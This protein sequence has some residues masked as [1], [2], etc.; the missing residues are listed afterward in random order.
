MSSGPITSWQIDG[1]TVRLYF[2]GLQNH[3][4]HEI[5]RHL[6]LGRKAMTNLDSILKSRH[7]FAN[8]D[9]YSQRCSFSSSQVWVWVLDL[10]EG[11][12]Q[13]NWCF[14]IDAAG[15]DSSE[16]LRLQ[17]DQIINLKRNQ[18]WIFI[19][20]TDAEAEAPI[21][22]PPDAKG[23]LIGKDPDAGKDW[24]Q[25]EKGM[26]EVEMVGWHHWLNGRE[27]EKTP[28]DSEGQGSLACCSPWDCKELDMTERLN[29]CNF[30]CLDYL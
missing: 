11:W 5:N 7:H 10:K 20:R 18:P 17:G 29:K 3:C 27:S 26:T 1:E 2:L 6:L 9:P 16:S 25:E 21:L 28:G 14:W 15:E 22:W 4:S 30:K 24:W 12:A 8:K 13:K 19:G 23:Q